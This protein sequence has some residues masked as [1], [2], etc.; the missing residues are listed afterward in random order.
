M[1]AEPDIQFP[2]DKSRHFGLFKKRFAR[3]SALLENLGVRAEAQLIEFLDFVWDVRVVLEKKGMERV[4]GD[5]RR[6]ITS[7]HSADYEP[8]L[9]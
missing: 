5:F 1:S 4:K 2:I 9:R 3:L 7:I 8:V 6:C